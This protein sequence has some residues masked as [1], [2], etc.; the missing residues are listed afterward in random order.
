LRGRAKAATSSVLA[1]VTG[2]SVMACFD[3]FHSTS[4][5]MR[6]CEIDGAACEDGGAPVVDSGSPGNADSSTDP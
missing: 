6:S 1:L 3:L 4:F 5:E 2:A